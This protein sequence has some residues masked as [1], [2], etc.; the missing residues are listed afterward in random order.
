MGLALDADSAE[1]KERIKESAIT[2]PSYSEFIGWGA[3]SAKAYQVKATPSFYL[4]DP[5]L[6]I[7]AKPYD[8]AELGR[9]L[10][11]FLP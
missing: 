1:F 3:S 11:G 9:L 7:V 8:A 10:P 2:W 4:L 6:H 5:K